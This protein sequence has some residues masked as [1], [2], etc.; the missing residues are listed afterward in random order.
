[1]DY[2]I[3]GVA[4]VKMFAGDQVF[5]TARTLLTSSITVSVT[6]TDVR[7]GQGDV[8]FGKFF[9]TSKFDLKIEDAM[10]RLEYIAAN[11]GANINIGGDVLASETVTLATSNVGTVA[12]APADFATYG[13]IGWVSLHGKNEWQKVTFTGST[14]TSPVGTVGDSVCIMY[15][16]NNTGARQLTV[17]SNIVPSTIRLVME[18]QLFAGSSDDL[19]SAT[20]VGIC[21]IE[22]PRFLLDGGVDIAMTSTGV[23]KTPF[24]G[25]ALATQ[26]A[27]C[28]GDGV[29]AIIT[30]IMNN[31]N[32]YDSVYVLGIVDDTITL[33]ASDTTEVLDVIAVPTAGN[34]FKP[35]YEDLTFVSDTPATCT[36][37]ADGTI[38][39]VSS[40]NGDKS[41][42]TVSITDKPSI[43]ATAEVTIVAP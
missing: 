7:G 11:I 10:F 25:S 33:S 40:T 18:A 26:S 43:T 23:S 1:M 16:N 24:N 31:S 39:K 9:H 21:Q 2:F 34:A 14:F 8:L 41:T 27:S 15:R 35:P 5:A 20:K 4:R 36:V 3:G 38:T 12:S 6:G 29:Y 30:E 22:V 37:S 17:S 13:K 28:D 42:I 32:W 19:N